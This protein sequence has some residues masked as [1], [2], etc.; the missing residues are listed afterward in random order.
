MISILITAYKEPKTIGKCIHTFL[1]SDNGGLDTDFELLLGC[2]DQ[3]TLDAARVEVQALGITDRFKHI[4]DEGKGK[5]AALS[6]MM[7]QAQGDVWFFGDGDTYFGRDAINKM[8]PHFI[9]PQVVAVTGRPR[10]AQSKDTMM[11]YWGNLLSDAANHKRSVDLTAT[12]QGHSNLF[13]H[14]RKFFPVSGY[15]FAMRKTEMRPPADCLVEDAYFSYQIYNNGGKIEYEPAAEVY[16][17]YASTLDDYFKQKNRSTGGYI[18]L[19]Q[20]GIVKPDTKTRSFWRELEYFWFPIRY[21]TNLRE[22][23]WSFL[24]YPVRLWMWIMIYWERKVVH[25]DFVKT[26]VR[27]ESTK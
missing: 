25:K 5:P 18:Q 16:V 9:N 27:V 20:Y 6:Q 3:E 4:Q 12:P 22:L 26:W 13:V 1:N 10:S 23:V 24:L 14:K 7:D 17:K 8:L 11:S 2:P 19:W 15:L 21:A